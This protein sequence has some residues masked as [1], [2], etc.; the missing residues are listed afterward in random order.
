MS[1]S[2]EVGFLLKLSL[3]D[4]ITEKYAIQKKMVD[5]QINKMKVIAMKNYMSKF[6]NKWNFISFLSASY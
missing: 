1:A 3:L 6:L 2:V 4:L 5:S